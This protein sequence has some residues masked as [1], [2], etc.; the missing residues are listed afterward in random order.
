MDLLER[1]QVLHH[2]LKDSGII[3]DVKDQGN[4]A[5]CFAHVGVSLIESVYAMKGVNM[6]FSVQNVLDK[7]K[8]N[9]EKGGKIIDVFDHAK[10]HGL[11]RED[12]YR[13]Y[14]ELK[15]GPSTSYKDKD[16]VQ[17][18]RYFIHDY[19]VVHV[20]NED[21]IRNLLLD[22]PIGVRMI[23]GKDLFGY[24]GGIF[25]GETSPSRTKKGKFKWHRIELIGFGEERGVR[26]FI[27][28][29]SWGKE[30][31]ENGY[32][33]IRSSRR[34]NT[35]GASRIYEHP[36]SYPILCPSP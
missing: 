19:N 32:M 9:P 6:S 34:P 23:V 31:G 29:N 12:A 15:D 8:Y 27:A 16:W 18:K 4:S 20:K 22:R 33:R 11:C 28:K 5:S 2:N 36:I 30:W 3:S 7:V 26:Y 13:P 25:R 17:T 14:T 24:D 1:S 35:Y 10:N 21:D